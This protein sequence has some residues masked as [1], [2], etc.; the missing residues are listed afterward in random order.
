MKPETSSPLVTNLLRLS[1]G[2]PVTQKQKK[3]SGERTPLPPVPAPIF[4]PTQDLSDSPTN[5][6]NLIPGATTDVFNLHLKLSMP[7]H[8]LY[9]DLQ[10]FQDVY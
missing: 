9:I 1:L 7:N 5:T 6:D 10:M 4:M 8:I 3:D 2:I